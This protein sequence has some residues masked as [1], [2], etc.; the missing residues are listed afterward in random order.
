MQ[1]SADKVVWV[2]RLLLSE[3][4]C[5]LVRAPSQPVRFRGECMHIMEPAVPATKPLLSAAWHS[6]HNSSGIHSPLANQ[7]CRSNHEYGYSMLRLHHAIYR[8]LMAGTCWV[9]LAAHPPLLPS[10]RGFAER[11][12]QLLIN[13]RPRLSKRREQRPAQRPVQQNPT[14]LLKN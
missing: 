12:K 13:P 9:Q 6:P 7:R 11:T 5:M 4:F 2:L 3:A 14:P 8:Q 1:R 10:E